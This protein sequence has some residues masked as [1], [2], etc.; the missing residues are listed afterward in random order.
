MERIAQLER[1][2]AITNQ[3]DKDMLE[4]RSPEP[5]EV[6]S[7]NQD[8][9][10]A[11]DVGR[12]SGISVSRDSSVEMRDESDDSMEREAA[13]NA[14][15]GRE[16]SLSLDLKRASRSRSPSVGRES[17][18]KK[19]RLDD[20]ECARA[21]AAQAEYREIEE[22]YQARIREW[23]TRHRIPEN[24]VFERDEA[25]EEHEK[26]QRE[27]EVMA[28]VCETRDHEFSTLVKEIVVTR[29]GARGAKKDYDDLNRN[30]ITGS[31]RRQKRARKIRDDVHQEYITSRDELE[32]AKRALGGKKDAWTKAQD[33]L[34]AR[35]DD[36]AKAEARA[37][38][39]LVF[40]LIKR[41]KEAI[42]EVSQNHQ[43]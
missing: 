39:T 16:D 34:T 10:L 6:T 36:L 29:E 3:G 5:G 13:G 32:A 43:L 11:A 40:T 26:A 19:A 27:L 17:R 33:D 35:K 22:A 20:P 31:E 7:Q 42:E 14:D 18:R 15:C 41:H 1:A 8:G 2:R 30:P 37:E 9:E 28:K 4:R 24:I 38:A 21:I 23:E 25:V 12:D